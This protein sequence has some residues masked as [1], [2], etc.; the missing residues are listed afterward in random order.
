[1][2]VFPR[3]HVPLQLHTHV[4]VQLHAHYVPPERR[5]LQAGGHH[6][7]ASSATHHRQDL[8]PVAGK[9][10]QQASERPVTLAEVAQRPVYGLH[11]PA[12]RHPC[13]VPYQEAAP[14]YGFSLLGSLF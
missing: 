1:M 11:R 4:C 7:V 2:R 13:L 9:Q 14:L 5:C 8:L 6:L 3:P 12:V 10:S